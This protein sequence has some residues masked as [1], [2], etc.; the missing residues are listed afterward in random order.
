MCSLDRSRVQGPRYIESDG[1]ICG[2]NT[3]CQRGGR[4][5]SSHG[6]DAGY[7]SNIVRR[8]GS[9]VGRV[10]SCP[11]AVVAGIDP[12][13]AERGDS[14]SKPG[15]AVTTTCGAAI[16]CRSSH[17]GPGVLRADLGDTRTECDR[18]QAEPPGADDSSSEPGH[19]CVDHRAIHA[20]PDVTSGCP[21][22]AYAGPDD[23]R[24]NPHLTGADPKLGNGTGCILRM[25]ESPVDRP[26][27]GRD[28]GTTGHEARGSADQSEG[29][30][31]SH[32]D[33]RDGRRSPQLIHI[34]PVRLM[35]I[36]LLRSAVQ[37]ALGLAHLSSECGKKNVSSNNKRRGER[38]VCL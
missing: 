15:R 35:R 26:R 24:T 11:T 38:D 19:T 10:G 31:T 6:A 27:A 36:A 22:F 8:D 14:R 13:Y 23:A 32:A 29:T 7:S 18:I 20:A 9:R 37:P 34:G 5:V 12:N 4:C 2:T 33:R 21:D 28:L 1:A 16:Q 30:M 17:A 3:R 25:P